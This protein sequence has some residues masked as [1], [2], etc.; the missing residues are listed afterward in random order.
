MVEHDIEQHH[1]GHHRQ[2]DTGATYAVEKPRKG[3]QGHRSRAA[4]QARPPELQR[5][6]LDLG[7]K[8]KGREQPMARIGEEQKKRNGDERGPE[9]GPGRLR[10]VVL[11]PGAKGLRGQRLHRH[12]DAVHQQKKRQHQPENCAHRRHRLGRDVAEKPG[13]GEIE[14]RGDAR[15]GDQRQR[16]AQHDAIVNTPLALRIEAQGGQG[17]G[18]V[19]GGGGIH[20]GHKRKRGT[21]LGSPA[22]V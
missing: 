2:R 5:Q 11:A 1:H 13:V 15:V 17:A 18:G 14:R 7:V 4:E 12:A 10:R 20:G 21:P 19:S 8:V 16:E 3:K 9:A 6:A 22:L